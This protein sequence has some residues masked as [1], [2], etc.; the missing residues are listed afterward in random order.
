MIVYLAKNIINGK[1]YIGKTTKNIS[2]RIK[3]H[4]THS[5]SKESKKYP[6]IRALLK[7]GY[8]NFIW[9]TICECSNEKELDEF[10]KYYIKVFNSR[11]STLGYNITAGG[12]GGD[13][14]TYNPNAD[15]IR[16]KLRLARIGYKLSD[17]TKE[18]IRQKRI[19][20]P[21]TQSTIDKMVKARKGR[22]TGPMK[23]ETRIKIGKSNS[24]KMYRPLALETINDIILMYNNGNSIEK[25]GALKG[26]S[27]SKIRKTLKENKIKIRNRTEAALIKD[28]SYKKHKELHKEIVEQIISLYAVGFSLNKISKTVRISVRQVKYNLIQN[29]VRIRSIKETIFLQDILIGKQRT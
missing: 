22:K 15:K 27:G 9:G 13:T 1:V 11:N 8:D 29:N 26:L 23:E 28:R 7:Y 21:R 10:E 6:F 12:E 17:E 18:K 25:I 20:I 3:S 14:F 16:D 5:K 2:Y 19:G 24:I 4:I